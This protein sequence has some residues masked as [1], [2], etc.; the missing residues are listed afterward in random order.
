MRPVVSAGR[1]CVGSRASGAAAGAGDGVGLF[2]GDHGGDVAVAAVAGSVGRALAADLRLGS[3]PSRL[4]WDNETAV[5]QWRGGRPQLTE[6][7]NAF[8]GTLAIKIVQCKPGDPESKGL[9]ERANGYLETSFLPGRS[10]TSP[11]DFNTQLIDLCCAPRERSRGCRECAPTSNHDRTTSRRSFEGDLQPRTSLSLRVA[12]PLSSPKRPH[13]R[14][15]CVHDGSI[16][17][18]PRQRRWASDRQTIKPRREVDLLQVRAHHRRGHWCCDLHPRPGVDQ[19]K[20]SR[21]LAKRTRPDDPDDERAGRPR[22]IR[23]YRLIGP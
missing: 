11:A 8:R 3:S 2:A 1:R 7:M 12:V 5:G 4:V 10:F 13:R 9:V 18:P 6:A 22:T 21:E 15:Y 23:Y 16:R 19:Q 20:R 14:G 17:G